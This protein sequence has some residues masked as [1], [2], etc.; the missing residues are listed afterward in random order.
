MVTIRQEDLIDIDAFPFVWR[1]TREPWDVLPAE[2][3]VKIHPLGASRAED[4]HER[5]SVAFRDSNWYFPRQDGF[6][7]RI[8]GSGIEGITEESNEGV[9]ETLRSFPIDADEQVYVTW[10]QGLHP[11]I[12][13]RWGDFIPIWDSLVYPFDIVN[14]FD[15]TMRWAVLFGPEDGFVYVSDLDGASRS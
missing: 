1:I 3:L 4:L 12:F 6:E 14:V 11:A 15:D 7:Q 5:S 8:G 2:T 10:H 13:I 9:K